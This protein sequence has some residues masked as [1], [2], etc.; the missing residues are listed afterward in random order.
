MRSFAGCRRK[1]ATRGTAGGSE[2]MPPL[3]IAHR[4]GVLCVKAALI[5][6]GNELTGGQTVDTNSAWLAKQLGRNGIPV[7]LHLT[8]GDSQA[9]IAATIRSAASGADVVIVT[10]GLGPTAD[11]V[12]RE[13]LAEALGCDLEL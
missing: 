10:G 6:I 11:D 7:A 1:T 9:D 5:A 12:T 2:K 4:R 3:Q 13:A 8:V